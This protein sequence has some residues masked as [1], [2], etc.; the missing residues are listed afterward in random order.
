MFE[1][2]INCSEVLT[3][4]VNNPADPYGP[5]LA[6]YILRV[7]DRDTGRWWY[8]RTYS[9]RKETGPRYVFTRDSTYAKLM[10]YR[11]ARLHQ[12]N[13]TPGIMNH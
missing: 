6:R 10:T 11:T 9:N 3:R 8:V 4:V 1:R 5:P 7:R 2:F 13:M 12:A